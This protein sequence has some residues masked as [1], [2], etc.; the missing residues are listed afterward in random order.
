MSSSEFQNS[1]QKM[2]ND[3]L[4]RKS[5]LLICANK[6]SMNGRLNVP[7]K[8]IAIKKCEFGEDHDYYYDDTI[9]AHV[10]RRISKI[11]KPHDVLRPI[12]SIEGILE[13]PYHEGVYLTYAEMAIYLEEGVAGS[14]VDFM[15]ANRLVWKNTDGDRFKIN[16]NIAVASFIRKLY[17]IDKEQEPENPKVDLLEVEHQQF[18]KKYVTFQMRWRRDLERKP[19]EFRKIESWET[20]MGGIPMHLWNDSIF[21]RFADV[22][23][24]GQPLYNKL[25]EPINH[26][27]EARIY[28][29]NN[30]DWAID[31]ILLQE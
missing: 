7:S 28:K 11:V 22:G 15:K 5:C 9:H 20:Y 6:R 10:F 8:I 27:V 17:S 21:M 25:P 14:G 3:I 24:D 18:L 12:E 31:E 19:E 30:P 1:S 23:E 13:H 4:P 26:H 16:M 2:E 29:I